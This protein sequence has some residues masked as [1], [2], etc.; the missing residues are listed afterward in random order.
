VAVYLE[1]PESCLAW[2]LDL[3]AV[4]CAACD[5]SRLEAR[6][7]EDPEKRERAAL[8]IVVAILVIIVVLRALIEN[9][10]ASRA[11][12]EVTF[13]ALTYISLFRSTTPRPKE[14]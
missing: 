2:L 11:L 10:S 4:D 6:I 14:I 1:V 3:G 9:K 12:L 13:A 8:G 5:R 7:D